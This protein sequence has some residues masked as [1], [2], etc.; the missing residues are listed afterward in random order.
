MKQLCVIY[1]PGVMCYLLAWCYEWPGVIV[2]MIREYVMLRETRVD[3]GA[4]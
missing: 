1:W 3:E 2:V 4:T